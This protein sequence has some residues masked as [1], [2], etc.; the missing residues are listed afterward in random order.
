MKINKA[1]IKIVGMIEC[2]A[3]FVNKLHNDGYR[4]QED[5]LTRGRIVKIVQIYYKNTFYPEV[6]KMLFLD[7]DSSST[8]KIYQKENKRI[9]NFSQ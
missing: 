5:I 2:P 4:L 9:V 3:D 1:I 7:N 6:R 8:I